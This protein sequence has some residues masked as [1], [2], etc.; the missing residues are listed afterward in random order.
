M[1][2]F[3]FFF[4][5]LQYTTLHSWLVLIWRDCYESLINVYLQNYIRNNTDMNVARIRV[6]SVTLYRDKFKYLL[7]RLINNKHTHVDSFYHGKNRFCFVSSLLR[8]FFS[9]SLLN[10][11]NCNT[12]KKFQNKYRSQRKANTRSNTGSDFRI[13]NSRSISAYRHFSECCSL[14]VIDNRPEQT[15]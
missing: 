7:P 13:I 6:S 5:P 15:T 10:N 2:F 3:V 9:S 8:C 1:T 4:L 12:E 14:I 11:S